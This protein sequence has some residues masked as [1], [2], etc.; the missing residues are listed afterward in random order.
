MI[1]NSYSL[2]FQANSRFAMQ[3]QALPWQLAHVL[4]I[5]QASFL[6]TCFSSRPEGT[7]SWHFLATVSFERSSLRCLDRNPTESEKKL[8]AM[9][10]AT[11]ALIFYLDFRLVR[12]FLEPN[13]TLGSSHRLSKRLVAAVLPHPRTRIEHDS[14]L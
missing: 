1:R 3:F 9:S 14:M 10:V 2:S 4:V 7:G 12:L 8:P 13:W 11:G 5:Q 6:A